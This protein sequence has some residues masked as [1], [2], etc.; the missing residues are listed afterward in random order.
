MYFSLQ[1]LYSST[2]FFNLYFLFLCW[3]SPW[4]LP[5]FSQGPWASLWSLHYTLYQASCCTLSYSSELLFCSFFWS[6]FLCVSIFFDVSVC[7]Y[8]LGE[9][10]TSPKLEGIVLIMLIFFCG[11]HVLGYRLAGVVAIVGWDMGKTAWWSCMV[12]WQQVK[13][14]WLG[15]VLRFSVK[16]VNWQDRWSQSGCRL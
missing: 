11:P 15:M 1:L 10:A 5:L 6:I 13:W 3:S 7:F 16:R 9:I 14:A 12:G 8:E 2:F 4:V